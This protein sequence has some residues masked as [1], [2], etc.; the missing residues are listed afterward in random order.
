M[1]PEAHE[2]LRLMKVFDESPRDNGPPALPPEWADEAWA[3]EQWASWSALGEGVRQSRASDACTTA[4]KSFVLSAI[5]GEKQASGTHVLPWPRWATWAGVGGG[6]AA[7][8][9]LALLPPSGPLPESPSAMAVEY[10]ESGIPGAS[11]VV[12]VDEESGAT[13]IWLLEPLSEEKNDG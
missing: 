1:N 5:A 7:A 13:V 9:T 8:L 3:Q 6:L 11:P 10:V 4:V 2:I 12:Y